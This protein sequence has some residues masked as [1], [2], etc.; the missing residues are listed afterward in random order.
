MIIHI[1]LYIVT[2]RRRKCI[3]SSFVHIVLQL[4][5]IFIVYYYSNV[6]MYSMAA[7]KLFQLQL[8]YIF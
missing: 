8:K 5:F 6:M 7:F 3:N 4:L 1:T 2:E